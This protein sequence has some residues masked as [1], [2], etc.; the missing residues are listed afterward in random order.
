MWLRGKGRESSAAALSVASMGSGF[1]FSR[2]EDIEDVYILRMRKE[3]L[4]TKNKGIIGVPRSKERQGL[5][6]EHRRVTDGLTEMLL[7]V[8]R[9]RIRGRVQGCVFSEGRYRCG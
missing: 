6:R 5:Y 8:L 7:N 9:L 4:K 2:W 3:C 1:R